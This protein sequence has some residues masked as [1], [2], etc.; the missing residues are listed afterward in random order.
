M[1][2]FFL[3]ELRARAWLI[4]RPEMHESEAGQAL[5]IFI[6]LG[7][8]TVYGWA[9]GDPEGMAA[10][11]ERVLAYDRANP[12]LSIPADAMEQTRATFESFRLQLL[13]RADE[14]RA[15]RIAAGAEVR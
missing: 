6:G 4:A 11:L 15:R 7:D 2:S 1:F 10:I 13:D 8:K 9:G 3:G 5:S 14:I 12:D